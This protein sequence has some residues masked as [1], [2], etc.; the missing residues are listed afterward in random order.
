MHL[1]IYGPEGSGKGTQARLLSEKLGHPI[2]TSGDIVREK[3]SNDKGTLGQ[4]C[5]KALKEGVYVADEIMFSLWEDK[6]KNIDKN[7]FILDGFPR[8]LAQ[9]EFLEKIFHERGFSLDKFIHLV[10][11][12]DD[13]IQ[14]LKLRKRTIFAGSKILHDDPLRIKKRLETY[15]MQEELIVDFFKN[16][17]L[18]L[19]VTAMGSIEE[20]FNR[21]CQGLNISP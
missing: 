19:E 14:R 15:R 10:L 8:T 12:N 3:A 9:A 4:S 20:V 16:K 7:G 18:L 17:N 2:Y 5:R 1:I 11:S 6:L 21:I 13:A